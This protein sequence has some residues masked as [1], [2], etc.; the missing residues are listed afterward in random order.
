[1]STIQFTG[2]HGEFMSKKKVPLKTP[3]RQM[4]MV[5]IAEL[6]P[7]KRNAR[8][9]TEKQIKQVI[10][11]IKEFGWTNPVLIDE[12]RCI[13]A[14]HARVEAAKRMGMTEVPCIILDGLTEAQKRA[15]V[16]ADNKLALNAGW[17]EEL[18]ALEFKDLEGMNFDL[19]LTGFESEEIKAFIDSID[20]G[21]GAPSEPVPIMKTAT[22]EQL[23]P[24]PEERL[25]FEGRKILVEFSGGKDSSGT[26]AW[27]RHFF[28]D[29]EIELCYADLGAD[30]P[31]FNFFI[32]DFA[33]AMGCKL[34]MLRSKE[35]I[36][37]GILRRGKWPGHFHPFCHNFLHQALNDNLKENDP[38]AV[39]TI[40][41]GA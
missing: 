34:T 19:G 36:I 2:D 20:E 30:H 10:A 9:H 3:K 1:M 15:Y 39:I 8:T 25:A 18:L 27:A 13:I 28:P 35:N 32:H 26:A 5:P 41:G 4:V 23:A 7:Y 12:K 6:Q 22:L 33:A 31:G 14:G 40:R 16:I 17:D 29:A 24:T 38:N 21:S 37:E 11:S